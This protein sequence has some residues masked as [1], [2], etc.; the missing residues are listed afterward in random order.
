[1]KYKLLLLLH[2]TGLTASAQQVALTSLQHVVRWVSL[3]QFPDYINQPSVQQTVLNVTGEALKKKFNTTEVQIPGAVDYRYISGFSR[4][5][6]Q[7]PSSG[8]GYRVSLMSYLTRA[9]V[10][11]AVLWKMEVQV[12]QGGN[13]VFQKS[14]EHELEYFSATGYFT[15]DAWMNEEEFIK[16]YTDLLNEAL[17]NRPPLEAKIVIGSI[18]KKEKAVLGLFTQPQRYLLKSAGDFFSAGNFMVSLQKEDSVISA[19]TYKDGWD[20]TS[21][22][23]TWASVTSDLFSEITGVGIGY[24]SKVKQKRLGK[25]EYADG[26]KLRLRMEWIDKV[27]RYG[28]NSV[29]YLGSSPVVTEVYEGKELVGSFVHTY[30]N[31]FSSYQLDG[32]L[33][34]VPIRVEFTPETGLITLKS[35]GELRLA[36]LMENVNPDSRAFSGTHLTKNKKLL[37][38]ATLRNG[39]SNAEWYYVYAD[40][41]LT[42]EDVRHYTEVI[43]FLFFGMGHTGSGQQFRM[44]NDP[45]EH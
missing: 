38:G 5:S 22:A 29:E 12:Q 15:N 13:T 1:M 40:A 36:V 37:I 30:H 4:G 42:A 25:L 2:L 39:L 33:K 28:K 44:Y 10:G 35:V 32:R 3:G 14:T 41:T 17:E 20:Q 43:T 45:I 26:R 21:E 31:E 23:L 7:K 16:Y 8:E 34:G 9:T 27:T 6:L 18:E 11:F 19:M 24:D